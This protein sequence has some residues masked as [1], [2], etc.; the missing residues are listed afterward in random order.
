MAQVEER[1]TTFD[2]GMSNLT[3]SLAACVLQQADRFDAVV[4][5]QADA[6]EAVF[7]R[8]FV[9]WKREGMVE[10]QVP[11]FGCIRFPLLPGIEDTLDFSERLAER[12]RVIVAPGEFFGASGHVRLGL[13]S[14]MTQLTTGLERFTNALRQYHS[15]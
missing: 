1:A 2:F 13:S 8:F 11:N 4:Q 6:F 14:D 5:A 7:R 15:P 9:E 12:D 3:H 10:G